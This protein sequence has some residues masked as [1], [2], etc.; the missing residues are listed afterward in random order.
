M[1]TDIRNLIVDKAVINHSATIK[2][3][4]EFIYWKMGALDQKTKVKT[5]L[6][7][8]FEYQYDQQFLELAE[9][10]HSKNLFKL[11]SLLQEH[12]KGQFVDM[13]HLKLIKLDHLIDIIRNY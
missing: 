10:Q 13:I 1:L 8:N 4:Y 7:T 9:N 11:F 6:L 2:D 12:Q 5:K 3:W